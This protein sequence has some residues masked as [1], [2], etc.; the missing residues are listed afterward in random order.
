MTEPRFRYLQTAIEQGALVVTFT[1][2]RL[3]GDEMAH[4]ILEELQAALAQAGTNKLVI[5]LEH[6][7]YLTS[8][9]FRPFLAIRK[10]LL[11]AGGRM[12]L[13]SLSP[14]VLE[15]FGVTR[16]IGSSSAASGYFETAPDV[17][18]ALA[19]LAKGSAPS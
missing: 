14:L 19:Q 13:C 18:A 9:H 5:N 10:Q 15:S 6:V 7:L 2:P 3:E 16:M 8:A 4:T 12:V 17:E 1:P 11:G